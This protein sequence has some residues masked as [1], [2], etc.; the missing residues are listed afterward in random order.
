MPRI[1]KNHF[2]SYKFWYYSSFSYEA[3]IYLYKA[4]EL[5]G[6]IVFIKGITC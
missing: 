5:V 6:R 1:I 3:L 4:G 2:D